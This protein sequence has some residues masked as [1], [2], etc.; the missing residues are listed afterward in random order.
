[1]EKEYL[2]IV[3]ARF[4]EIKSL[5]EKTIHQLSNKELH[6]KPNNE[7][8]SIAI[9]VKHVSGNMVSRWTDFLTTDGEKLNGNRNDE[10]LDTISSIED[11][12]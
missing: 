4:N 8:N 2:N 1:M 6:W 5:G 12:R 7:S 3:I 11:L 10:F 9:I